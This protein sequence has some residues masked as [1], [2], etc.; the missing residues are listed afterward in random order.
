MRLRQWLA[1][2]LESLR[3]LASGLRVNPRAVVFA[4]ACWLLWSGVREFSPP[5][6][7]IALALL[8]LVGLFWPERAR[9]NRP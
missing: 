5:A 7:R 3:T 8:M 4:A 6:A 1:P 2:K 9:R